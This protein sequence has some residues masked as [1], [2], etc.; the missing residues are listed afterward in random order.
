[1]F[2]KLIC[3]VMAVV[4]MLSL[5]G[6]DLFTADTAELLS[7]P[8]LSGDLKY[9][10][11]A[12]KQSAG[13]GYTLKFPSRGSNR[14]AVILQDIDG[15]GYS[16]AFAFYSMTDGD[17]VTMHINIIHKDGSRWVSAGEQHVVAAGVDK[18]EFCDLDSDG[19]LDILVGWEIYG[20]S[21]KQLAVYSFKNNS[22]T[23]RI[24]QKYTDFVICD[25][26]E[27]KKSEILVVDFVSA[28][29][30]NTATL[31]SIMADGVTQLGSCQ[32]DSKVQS[33]GEPIVSQLSSGKPAVYIDSVKGVGA[34]TEVLFYE[35]G[36]LINN[37]YDIELQE[38]N[39]TLR[40]V[41]FSLND[42]NNDKILE[43]P[44]QE[45]VPSVANAEVTEKLYL[46]NWCTFNGEV[47]TNQLTTMINVLDGYYYII[48]QSLV[49]KI[50]ILKDTDN[51][52]REMYLFDNELLLVGESILYLRAFSKKQWD[53]GKFSELGLTEIAQDGENVFACKI[54][55]KARSAG[56]TIENV[57]ANFVVYA[58]E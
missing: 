38:T 42:I 50:A 9:I 47:L 56:F 5:C 10:S 31:F 24:L 8:S 35:K 57:K 52:I 20:A 58:K 21:E 25:L 34:I 55:E 49:G 28:E 45:N 23:Q 3:A 17:I 48:P 7:P 32:L 4:L 51:R 19:I 16:E 11:Q 43:I 18:I 46:T 29:P 37:L 39:K 14:S 6:C 2:K 41:S 40:S 22:M 26:D 13:Q 33:V 15:D 30:K 44:V 1:M 54:S 53:S 27:D 12:I 36:Q